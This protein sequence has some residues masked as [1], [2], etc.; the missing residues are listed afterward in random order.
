MRRCGTYVG[1]VC[2]GATEF[3]GVMG[4]C[5]RS[6]ESSANLI[7]ECRYGDI[8]NKQALAVNAK[9]CCYSNLYTYDVPLRVCH[10]SL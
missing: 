9:A 8:D 10:T 7:R 5:A 4:Y 6:M 1:K 2:L 3:V